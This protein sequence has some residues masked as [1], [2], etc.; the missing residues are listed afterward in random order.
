MHA[1]LVSVFLAAS[2]V[3]W[4][5]Y[6]VFCFFR[7]DFL[8]GIAGVSASTATG[9]IELRA[10]YGGLQAAIGVLAGL[11]FVR[12]SLRRA[13]LVALL[14][15]Y[16]GLGLPRLAATLAAGEVSAY[17]ASALVLELGAATLTAWCLSR[18]AR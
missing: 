10:M 13:A 17:T 1:V 12:P 6:G 8:A 16:A 18:L 3:L 5:P 14:C 9:V 11:A 15:A 4:L 7:P 2:A